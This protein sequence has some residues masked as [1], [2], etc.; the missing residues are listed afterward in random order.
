VSSGGEVDGAPDGLV[1]RPEVA[2]D[3]KAV[4][5]VHARAFGDGDRVPGLPG[6]FE[7][8]AGLRPAQDLLTSMARAPYRHK[9]TLRIRG[10]LAQIRRRLPASVAEVREHGDAGWQRAEIRAE[11]FDWLPGV[12]AAL[13]LPFVIERPN[14]LRDRVVALADRLATWG[15]VR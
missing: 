12:L 11:S 10:T 13:D 7:P 5:Q 15:R 2:G 14:E 9:V 4:R 3:R 6:S 8:P 1:I